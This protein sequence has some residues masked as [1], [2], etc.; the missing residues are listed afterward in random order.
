MNRTLR[1]ALL[2]AAGLGS[3]GGGCSSGGGGG[4]SGSFATQFCAK[5]SSCG[6]SLPL[7]QGAFSALVLSSSCQQMLDGLTCTDLSAPTPPAWFSS[8]FP[9]CSTMSSACNGDGT[10]T[11][12]D[13]TFQYV[14]ECTGIC[15][16][17]SLTY[18]GT[19]GTSYAGNTSTTAKCWCM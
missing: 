19:C 2:L 9:S 5:V 4:S 16:A 13:G 3:A 7:C 12:C 10:I 17:E 18:T 6:Q 11:E 1:A 14:Y 8:C 15:T